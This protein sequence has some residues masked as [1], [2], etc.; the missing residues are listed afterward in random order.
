MTQRRYIHVYM[1]NYV[2]HDTAPNLYYCISLFLPPSLPPL[3]P[4]PS[5]HKSLSVN[6]ALASPLLSRFDLVL[7]LLDSH[8]EVWDRLISSF[9]LSGKSAPGE[10]YLL[11]LGVGDSLLI[12]LNY[13]AETV[14]SEQGDKSVWSMDKMQAY[15]SYIKSLRPVLSKEA[16]RYCN[17]L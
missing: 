11:N 14:V 2:S 1:Y 4:F 10:I 7:V 6:V 16:D 3:P 13:C 12:L 5:A 15:F 17:T 9:I 8:N